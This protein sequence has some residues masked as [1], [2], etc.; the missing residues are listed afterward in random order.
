MKVATGS[1]LGYA[2]YEMVVRQRSGIHCAW[3]ADNCAL[4]SLALKSYRKLF[5]MSDMM[6]HELVAQDIHLI[7]IIERGS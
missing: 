1:I 4:R 6:A 5:E 7:T 2:D 3:L